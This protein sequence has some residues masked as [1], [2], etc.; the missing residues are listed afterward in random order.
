MKRLFGLEN[1]FEVEKD[2]Y[3]RRLAQKGY[4]LQYANYRLGLEAMVS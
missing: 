4:S 2:P 1:P 3:N